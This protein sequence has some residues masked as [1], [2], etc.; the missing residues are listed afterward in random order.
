MFVRLTQYL[1]LTTKYGCV[2]FRFHLQNEK[3][4]CGLHFR[5]ENFLSNGS[6][7]DLIIYILSILSQNRV[8]LAKKWPVFQKIR[9]TT[10]EE[11]WTSNLFEEQD[12]DQDCLR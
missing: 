9:L 11:I 8:K 7:F 2:F 3:D 6:I 1:G 12:I 5:A 4:K 10:L